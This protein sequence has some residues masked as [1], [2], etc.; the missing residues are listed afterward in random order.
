MTYYY[1]GTYAGAFNAIIKSKD[2]ITWEYVSTPSF[3]NKSVFENAVYVVGDKV[4]YFVRQTDDEEYG[5]LAT[6]DLNAGRWENPLLIKDAQSR[7]DFIFY[8][9][10]LYLIHAPKNRNG[11]GVV[12]VDLTNIAKSK[13]VMVADMN[14]SCFYPYA[15]VIGNDVYFAYTV[16]RKHIRLSKFNAA[17]LEQ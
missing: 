12:R 13:A 2:L 1:T 3:D 5:F 15:K 16:D 14:G 17:Y 10:N 7:S 4:Y 6:Y 11:F 8:K 9:D